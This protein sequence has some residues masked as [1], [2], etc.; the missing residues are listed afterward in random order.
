[1]ETPPI[2]A[3]ASLPA[4][5]QLRPVDRLV[6]HYAESHRHPT[7]VRI[8]WVCVPIIVWCCL[9]LLHAI[10]PWLAYAGALLALVYYLRLSWSFALA[11]ALF[12]GLCLASLRVVPQ[13]AWVALAL[14]VITWILQFYGHHV[15]GRR[16]SFLEDLQYLL[17]GPLFLLAKAYRQLGLAY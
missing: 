6:G 8:H 10:H 14:F 9:A 16:P 1:M 15:E 2:H 12:A 4:G 13:A 7:N 5:A 3:E 17:V 11:M